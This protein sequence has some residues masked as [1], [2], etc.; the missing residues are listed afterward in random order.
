MKTDG[1]ACWWIAL[2]SVTGWGVAV[3]WGVGVLG[4]VTGVAV[5]GKVTGVGVGAGVA[6]GGKTTGVAVGCGVADG[7]TV[8]VGAAVTVGN[9]VAVGT[10]VGSGGRVAVGWGV[11]VGSGVGIA[12]GVAVGTA[13][14]MARARW[15][16]SWASSSSEGPQASESK[17]RLNIT[18]LFS[19]VRLKRPKV[20]SNTLGSLDPSTSDHF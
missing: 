20:L 4:I 19:V 2:K 5:G 6:V 18:S 15:S 7:M 10:R 9:S 17:T 11:A 14:T 3:G 16:I 12:C 1:Q 13:S 8:A